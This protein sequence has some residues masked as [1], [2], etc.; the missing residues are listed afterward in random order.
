MS[1]ATRIVLGLMFFPTAPLALAAQDYVN[2]EDR[3]T[4]GQRRDTG[5][6]TLTA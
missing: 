2:V 1:A 3:L 6:D 4:P 5:L